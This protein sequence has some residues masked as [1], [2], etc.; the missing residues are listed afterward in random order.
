[1][2]V[3]KISNVSR[4]LTYSISSKL[5]IFFNTADITFIIIIC[6]SNIYIIIN[7]DIIVNILKYFYTLVTQS[8][9]WHLD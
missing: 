8:R 9:Y 6:H 3:S 1:M 5:Y 7:N 2:V 4:I